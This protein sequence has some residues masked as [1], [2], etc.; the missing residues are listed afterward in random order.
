MSVVRLLHAAASVNSQP[1]AVLEPVLEIADSVMTYRRQFFAAP[2][3]TGVLALV[4]RDESNPRALAFQVRLLCEHSRALSVDSKLASS[5]GEQA[6]TNAL[7]SELLS[8]NLK[9]LATQHAQG[10][11]QPLL[12][13]LIALGAKLAALS[14]EVTSRYFNHIEPTFD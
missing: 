4:L 8:A 13:L 9:E 14:D 3:L 11:A 10:N 7:A 12:Q 5:E 2:Q 1:A 6:R